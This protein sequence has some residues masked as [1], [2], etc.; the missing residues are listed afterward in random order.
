[1]K[2][3]NDDCYK[4]IKDIPDNSVDLVYTDIPYLF[5]IGGGNF[6]KTKRADL[7]VVA[8]TPIS[9]GI[10]YAIL[11]EMVRIL[12]KINVFI[13]CSKDQLLTFWLFF[14]IQKG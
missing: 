1:M 10:D 9:K 3:I 12:K 7:Y 13:W 6:M 2:L 8:L 11:D 4:A 14:N 5:H